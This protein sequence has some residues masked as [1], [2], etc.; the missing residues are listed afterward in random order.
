MKYLLMSIVVIGLCFS[1]TLPIDNA[2]TL[3]G[4]FTEWR[5]NYYH[6]A[7]DI[8]ANAYTPVKAVK[9]GVV[10]AANWDDEYGNYV[11][12]KDDTGF[13]RYAH[14]QY[15]RVIPGQQ[16][17]EGQEIAGVGNTGKQRGGKRMG[18]HLH[19]ERRENGYKVYFTNRFIRDGKRVYWD[20][21]N[22]R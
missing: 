18:S 7:L 4:W 9:S 8:P 5:G 6:H 22:G 11:D 14:L 15:Y 21:R 1:E 2:T 17:F 3:T 13:Y 20:I 12:V 16:V 19:L 10:I